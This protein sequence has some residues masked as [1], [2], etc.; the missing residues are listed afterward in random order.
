MTPSLLAGVLVAWVIAQVALGVF[1]CLA[2][3]LGR[4]EYSYLLFGLLCFSLAVTSGGIALGTLG[5]PPE[6]WLFTAKIAHVGVIAAPVLNLHFALR[7][8]APERTRQLAPWLYGAALSFELANLF[9]YWWVP[10]TARVHDNVVLGGRLHYGSATPTTLALAYYALTGFELVV[11]Q[12]LF[13]RAY[14]RGNR[15]ALVAFL[16]GL[17]VLGAGVSDILLVT[18]V[19]EGLLFVQPHTFMFYAFAVAT[20]LIFRYRLTAGELEAVESS[21]RHAAEELRVSH[22]ELK[23]VQSTLETKEQLAAVGEL[24]AAIA[25]EVRNPLAIIG[26]A[27]AGLRRTEVASDDQRVLLDIVEEEAGRLNRLVTDLLRF[28]RPASLMPAA[29]DLTELAEAVAKGARLERACEV[30]LEVEP[31]QAVADAA[32]LRLALSN[33]VENACQASP[34]GKPVVVAI[35]QV[36]EQGVAQ[37]R[38]EV[39]DEGAGMTP[40]VAARACDPFFT[41][42]PSG[43]GLG[44]PIVQRI[45]RAHGG[46][47]ELESAP[48]RGSKVRLLFPAAPAVARDAGGSRA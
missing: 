25:H 40:E 15:E 29:V 11:T 2:F 31:V 43:T 42:R 27:V 32:L 14:R 36:D 48:G 28:A 45:I 12:L 35:D 16:G 26:N 39:R 3:A 4:R 17:F 6:H 30:R 41:T 44:L 21:L 22:L 47:V 19:V 10:G 33:V 20:T 1:F 18:G 38:I 46:R 7:Y 34:E 37:V 13:L 5:G 24:A 23:E 8:G 9:D